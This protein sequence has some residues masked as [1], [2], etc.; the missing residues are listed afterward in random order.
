MLNQRISIL[1]KVKSAAVQLPDSLSP[2]MISCI[3]I[4]VRGD[5][6]I[7]LILHVVLD[8]FRSNSESSA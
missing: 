4:V 6:E 8:F 3:A 1:S 7:I 5:F 2:V